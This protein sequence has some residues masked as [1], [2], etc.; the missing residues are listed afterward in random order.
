MKNQ[1]DF[2]Y[3]YDDGQEKRLSDFLFEEMVTP[4]M[5]GL[6]KMQRFTDCFE[7]FFDLSR[8]NGYPSKGML[9]IPTTGELVTSDIPNGAIAVAIVH[10]N[11]NEY[12]N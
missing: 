2:C 6:R 8:K 4:D 5:C 1:F 9:G 7:I 11:R 3:V 12:E 10:F